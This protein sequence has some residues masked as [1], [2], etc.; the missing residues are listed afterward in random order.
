MLLTF[1]IYKDSSVENFYFNAFCGSKWHI[2]QTIQTFE[3]V[4]SLYYSSYTIYIRLFLKTYT[5]LKLYPILMR[6]I[7]AYKLGATCKMM[8]MHFLVNIHINNQSILYKVNG[9]SRLMPP[10]MKEW[11]TCSQTFLIP[12]PPW[13]CR[14]C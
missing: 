12:T 9:V 10:L 5:N 14:I 8:F 13:N 1:N 2:G 7:C 6:H 3:Q 4:S 11:F